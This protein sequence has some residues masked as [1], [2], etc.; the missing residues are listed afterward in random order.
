MRISHLRFSAFFILCQEAI[1]RG[2]PGQD[3][4]GRLRAQLLRQ[5]VSALSQ[6]AL[7]T[8]RIADKAKKIL[9]SQVMVRSIGPGTDLDLIIYAGGRNR[10][11][12]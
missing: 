10:K 2:A 12:A 5:S 7:K 9:L 4:C 11:A 8:W 6:S 1:D 3:L